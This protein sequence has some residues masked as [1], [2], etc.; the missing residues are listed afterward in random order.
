MRGHLVKRYNGS[1]S[2][3]LDLG[4]RRDPETGLLKRV[5][6]WF[7]C[8]GTKKEAEKHLNDLLHRYHR[9][10]VIEP[11]K[12][13]LCDWLDRWLDTAVKPS[14]ALRTYETYRSIIN[15]HLKPHLGHHAIGALRPD[16]I[17]A[18]YQGS[19]LA[20]KTLENHQN[21]LSGALAVAVRYKLI[22]DNV[23][24]LV[25]NKPRAKDDPEKIQEQ[26]WDIDEAR[27]FLDTAKAA[28]PRQAAFYHLALE[29]G[30]RKGE[31]C[32]FKW[33]DLNFETGKIA[34]MRQLIKRWPVPIFGPPKNKKPRT[35]DLSQEAL[36]LLRKQKAAQ[37]EI[38]LLAGNTYQDYGL[39]F[40]YDQPPF[41]MPLSANN[42]G[43]REFSKLVKAAKVRP[44]T[45]HGLRH[46]AATLMLKAGIP[47]KVVSERLGHKK[48]SITLE[49]YAHALPSMQ[50]DAATKLGA[51]FGA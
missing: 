12:I 37:A 1:W 46:T 47:I 5:Q 21:V 26:C 15:K 22:R 18:Y 42:L 34:V 19:K 2:I 13:L 10:D 40:A 51:L 28:G 50:R 49:I 3:V 44:I 4:R 8:T 6:K 39:I 17:E 38:K 48:V 33:A 9:G 11:S 25:M 43:Q 24:R 41:G 45:I 14:N 31:L 36:V 27:A 32:G 29:T 23:A 20:Q 16:H 30:A 7:S 35:I